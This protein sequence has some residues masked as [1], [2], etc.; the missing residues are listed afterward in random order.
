MNFLDITAYSIGCEVAEILGSQADFGLVAKQIEKD[1][2]MMYV[3]GETE[4]KPTDT[5]KYTAFHVFHA[6]YPS[7]R[8]ESKFL[9]ATAAR[10]R[11]SN[12]I[13]PINVSVKASFVLF[14]FL[15]ESGKKA[16]QVISAFQGKRYFAQVGDFD[17]SADVNYESV[18]LIP[19]KVVKKYFSGD[20]PKI[21]HAQGELTAIEITYTANILT[22]NYCFE[23]GV[24]E[25]QSE[26]TEGQNEVLDYELDA[27]LA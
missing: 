10:F 25:Q 27:I 12:Q 20:W 1:G 17:L 8:A 18:E 19:A 6:I 3:A 2:R 14:G 9:K 7:A 24:S 26:F 13:A 22:C 4:V 21:Q 5:V 16:F 15:K 23:S 11:G